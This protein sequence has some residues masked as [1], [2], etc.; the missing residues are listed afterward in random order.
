MAYNGINFNRAR[1][2]AR[3]GIIDPSRM[4]PPQMAVDGG[5]MRQGIVNAPT[6]REALMQQ[7][8]PQRSVVEIL[9]EPL[10]EMTPDFG[11]AT[12]AASR[13]RQIADMLLQGAQQQDNTSIAGGLSQ[14]GQA[15]LA[16]RA[17]QKADAAEDKQRE[18]ASLLL[19]QAMGEGPESQ[20][21]RA[22]LFAD[23]PAA[24]V[25]QSDAQ[26]ATQA[27]QQRTQMQNEMIANLY[28]EGSKERAMILAGV[29]ATEATK[30]AFAPPPEP[31]SPIQVNGVL[32]DPV[33][34]QPIADFR[35]P[36]Q[37]GSMTE[38]QRAQLEANA[39][40]ATIP[41]AAA[42]RPT[43]E[44][45]NGVL[46]Y[47]D[48]AKEPVFPDVTAAPATAKP[49]I[50]SEAMARVTAGLPN[51]KQ[52]VEDLDRLVFR[53][54]STPL[55]AEG[56]DPASDWGAATIEAIPDFGLFKGFARTV[57]GED[58]QLFK[59][60]YGSFEAAMLP[61][62]SGAAI[63]ESEGLRQMR[64]LE[65]KPGDSEQTKTRKIAGMRSMVQGVE[66]A[67]RGDTAGFMSMLDEAGSLSGA[68]PLKRDGATA[69][70]PPK[71]T[72]KVA[73][74]LEGYS[75]DGDPITEDDI[76]T[77][78]RENNMT[79]AQVIAALKGEGQ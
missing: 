10:G 60:S 45:Q 55:S 14:L 63:T 23:S 72:G 59:D 11:G 35:T 6:M 30:Q 25:A 54:K 16:R 70:A 58:Y 67:A 26:R 32:V 65:I 39:A 3:Q 48:G 31:A 53:S 29:G 27:E 7:S 15:F 38:Y 22:Q 66:M 61:I 43:R 62:I 9:S 8:G 37:T 1:M 17:G 73:P 74:E 44:D 49:L 2:P 46:R 41:E 50:G 28:P 52:A 21:A 19:Q 68:G 79:R 69:A 51:A 57:G 75:M 4:G 13:Q 56:Y 34:Y 5:S 71:P 64:A 42:P 33:T 18:K 20:A 76:Q 78:M 77:T 47:M 40:A 36:A 12:S 24:L